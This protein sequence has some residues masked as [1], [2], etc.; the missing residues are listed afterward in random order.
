MLFRIDES[1]KVLK[2][3]GLVPAKMC[4]ESHVMKCIVNV[5]YSYAVIQECAK[6]VHAKRTIDMKTNR[7]IQPWRLHEKTSSLT[8]S[9]KWAWGMLRRNNI[10]KRRITTHIARNTPTGDAVRTQMSIIQ[11]AID[12][13]DIPPSRVFNEGETGV[14]WNPELKYVYAPDDADRG[15]SPPGDDAGRFTAVIGSNG[16]GDFRH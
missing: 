8:F 5:I 4:E 14:N 16:E 1:R 11:H 12:D 10:Y 2:N 9:K 7:V 6:I 15:G 3:E 13:G